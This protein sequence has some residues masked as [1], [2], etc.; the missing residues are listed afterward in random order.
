MGYKVDNAVILAAGTSSRF[1]PLSYEKPKALI[2]VRGEVLIE[3][4]IRQLREAGIESIAVVTGYKKEAFEYLKDKYGVILLENREYNTRNNH[5]SIFAAKEYLRNSYI[6]SADNYFTKNPFETEEGG[7]YYSAVYAPEE[8]AE[9][10]M[11]TDENGYINSVSIGGRA[12]WYMLGHVFWDEIF[13][14]TFLDILEREY[15][16]PQTKEKLWEDIFVGHIREL[17]MKMKC[18]EKSDILEFDCLE[19][20]REFDSKYKTESGSTI[21]RQISEK[22]RCSEADIGKIQPVKSGTNEAE[23]FCFQAG[24]KKYIYR[25]ITKEIIQRN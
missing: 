13:S 16:L 3:R 2:P 15:N 17:H 5:S 11:K 7:S 14:K 10:C 23:G 18:Y 19:E 8:T 20:L 21:L 25:Y 4:Q 24:G 22:L 9:W 1:A 12:S 6:C